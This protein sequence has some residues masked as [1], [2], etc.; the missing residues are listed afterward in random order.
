MKKRQGERPRRGRSP[1]GSPGGG[2]EGW[3]TVE[4]RV[5]ALGGKKVRKPGEGP[6]AKALRA[7][8]CAP[9]GTG[10]PPPC[11]LSA[12]GAFLHGHESRG[13]GGEGL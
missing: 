8:G 4:P 2:G 9:R 11:C 6:P 13:E 7:G 5:A 1:E 10:S 3:R 12:V